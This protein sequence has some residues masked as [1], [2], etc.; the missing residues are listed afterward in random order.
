[1]T[2]C[3]QVTS[4]A[5]KW[6]EYKPQRILLP[7]GSNV[8]LQ[9][10]LISAF[11]WHGYFQELRSL[12]VA[13]Q[14]TSIEFRRTYPLNLDD[15]D[16]PASM[17]HLNTIRADVVPASPPQ[18]MV[19]YACL[20][21]LDMTLHFMTNDTQFPNWFSQLTQL[22]TLGVQSAHGVSSFAVCV[23][24][25]RQLSSLDLKYNTLYRIELPVEITQF[26]VHCRYQTR[27]KVF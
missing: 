3:T 5:I 4:L 24:H 25:L 10:L 26:S 20:R 16:W 15:F 1:M 7:I 9:R 11:N 8:Q 27:S 14:L 22:E 18:Q 23:L 19:D 21:H 2:S 13:T 17:P 12:Q 6:D